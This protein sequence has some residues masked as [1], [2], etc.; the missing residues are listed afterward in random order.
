MKRRNILAVGTA[1]GG[2]A[3]LLTLTTAFKTNTKAEEKKHKL[4]PGKTETEWNYGTLSADDTGRIAYNGY[5]E[6][7]CMYAV[8]NSIIQQLADRFGEPYTAFPVHMMKYGHGGVGGYGTLC[9]ALNG[10][11]AMIGLVVP[12]KKDQNALIA[13]LF[14]WYEQSN[15]PVYSPEN[16]VTEYTPEPSKAGSPLCHASV[17]NWCKVSGHGSAGK[18]RK[19]RCSRL[20]ADVAIQA[21]AMLN[22]YFDCEYQTPMFS[23]ETSNT[24][25]TCHGKEG[26]LENTSGQ[27]SCT[28]CHTKSI[29]H[30]L[31][32]DVHYKCIEEKE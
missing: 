21:T 9:G 1:A 10:A 32:A 29:G 5:A 20:S 23:G 28:A 27:M 2:G 16:P 22:R 31:F 13:D 19:E 6:G 12:D 17:S 15:L 7:S 25:L 3:C 8:A 26:K 30:R 4:E 11:A 14:R 18:Q 24:C